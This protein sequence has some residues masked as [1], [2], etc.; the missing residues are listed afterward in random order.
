MEEYYRINEM[1]KSMAMFSLTQFLKNKEEVTF[2]YLFGDFLYANF[3]KNLNVGVHFN[4]EITKENN[5][6]SEIKTYSSDLKEKLF[7]PIVFIVL[8]NAPLEIQVDAVRGTIL[9]CTNE[10]KRED[11]LKEI[12][13]D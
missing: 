2:A 13:Q 8:N 3:F 5:W 4:P 10:A 1:E 12:L 9:S 11:F 6:D 7:Y